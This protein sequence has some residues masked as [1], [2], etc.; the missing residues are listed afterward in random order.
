MDEGTDPR[1][2]I[3]IYAALT[4]VEAKNRPTNPFVKG[5]GI[6]QKEQEA[7]QFLVSCLKDCSEYFA[8]VDEM[9]DALQLDIQGN[10]ENTNPE[11]SQTPK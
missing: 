3:L 9:I 2:L 4:L 6:T 5:F 11:E 8:E 1:L 10:L 7:Y